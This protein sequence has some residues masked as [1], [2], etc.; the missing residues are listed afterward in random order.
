MK[1]RFDSLLKIKK[2]K[3][4]EKE[5][6]IIKINALIQEKFDE[7]QKYQEQIHELL[8]PASG[9]IQDFKML[10]EYKQAFLFRIDSIHSEISELKAERSKRQEEYKLVSIDYEK[11]KHLQENEQKQFILALKKQ[12]EKNIDE[13]ASIR[14]HTQKDSL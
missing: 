10:A 6:E 3:L 2:Q 8:T 13:I 12:E 5:L 11:T 7:V 4:R 9:N 1:T 14:F